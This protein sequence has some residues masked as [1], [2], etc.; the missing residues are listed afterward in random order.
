M[1]YNAYAKSFKDFALC[2]NDDNWFEKGKLYQI[3]RVA[4]DRY[5]KSGYALMVKDE[6]G[7]E[8]GW[9]LSN[10]AP[11]GFDKKTVNILYGVQKQIR[12][13]TT[14]KKKTRQSFY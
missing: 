12:K 13:N 2:L 11:K 4:S 8:N 3:I 6:Q 5:Y 14:K 9:C 1:D 7:R 10:F